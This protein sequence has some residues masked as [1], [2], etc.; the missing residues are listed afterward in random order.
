VPRIGAAEEG[1]F[2]DVGHRRR[3]DDDDVGVV[4]ERDLLLR[5]LGRLHAQD[6]AVDFLDRAFDAL[7][8]RG[9]TRAQGCDQRTGERAADGIGHGAF[10]EMYVP[11]V[12]KP[13]DG[14]SALSSGTY[15]RIE[16]T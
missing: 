6:V 4:G 13:G 11:Q 12:Y 10:S 1:A 8:L 9:G 15:R 14:G 16:R 3:H 2:L 7:G 5:A